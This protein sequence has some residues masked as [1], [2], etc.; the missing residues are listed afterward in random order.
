[1][2][3]KNTAF[4]HFQYFLR[5]FVESWRIGNHF[6]RDARKTAEILGNMT[7][8]INEGREFIYHLQP[9]MLNN[10]DLGNAPVSVN[11]FPAAGLDID[12]GKHRGKI[13]E[14]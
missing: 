14:L 11:K 12:N 3:Y 8:R 10:A 7:F 5:H 6:I 2:S 4:G 13:T 9:V 1:M